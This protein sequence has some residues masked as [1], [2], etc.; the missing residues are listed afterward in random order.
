M[1]YHPIPHCD[2]GK[3]LQY[4]VS[5]TTLTAMLCAL[6][7]RLRQSR[8]IIFQN[9]W[10]SDTSGARGRTRTGMPCGE[11][12]SSRFGFRRRHDGRHHGVRGLEHAFTV[13]WSAVG[14]RRLLSTP[15]P[16]QGAGAWL[17]VGSERWLQGV[18]RLWRDPL[19]PFPAGG[20]NC[21]SPL[22]LPISPLG[23]DVGL[24]W[25]ATMPVCR[26]SGKFFWGMSR[27]ISN[28]R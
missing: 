11:G 25:A 5:S 4:L 7:P 14:A 27:L 28:V 17:G 21:S 23:L 20:S 19:R 8:K 24:R 26:A 18:R 1:R 10:L 15:S 9:K 13:A 12:F 22:C 3:I 2:V 6:M 16:A